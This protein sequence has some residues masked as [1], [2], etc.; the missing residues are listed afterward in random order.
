[1][2]KFSRHFIIGAEILLSKNFHIRGA[3]NF[4]RRNELIVE[5]K[6]GT[7]GFSF[8]VG[9]KVSKFVISYGRGNY[10]VGAAANHLSISTNLSEFVRK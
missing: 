6:P 1:L 2:N 7:V 5:G 10:H 4:Q 8:G 3:Y 9:L